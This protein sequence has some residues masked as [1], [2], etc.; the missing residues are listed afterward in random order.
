MPIGCFNSFVYTHGYL[1]LY[2][3]LYMSTY[4]FLLYMY[5][6]MY[7]YMSIC[8]HM[9]VCVFF[10]MIHMLTAQAVLSAFSKWFFNDRCDVY[11]Q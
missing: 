11:S 9:Y 2:I 7:T 3:Y 1:Y 6:Y 10:H 8:V 4:F 5:S